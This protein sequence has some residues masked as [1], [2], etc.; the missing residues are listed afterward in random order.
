[1]STSGSQNNLQLWS[2]NN[3][4]FEDDD[5]QR[6]ESG[7]KRQALLRQSGSILGNTI[8]DHF[9]TNNPLYV[10]TEKAVSKPDENVKPV[11]G[12]IGTLER[13]ED[14]NKM[15]WETER[16]KQTT[17]QIVDEISDNDSL[18][19]F[20]T[21]FYS[22]CSD[23]EEAAPICFDLY[24]ADFNDQG[25]LVIT[26]KRVQYDES[27]QSN[28]P[29]CNGIDTCNDPQHLKSG[30][31]TPTHNRENTEDCQLYN[32]I[33]TLLCTTANNKHEFSCIKCAEATNK[34]FNE[35][36]RA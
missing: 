3:P 19:S 15:Q 36:T 9:S 27:H 5:R 6:Q 20:E 30:I 2:S 32:H 12:V 28:F 13:N 18:Q 23:D 11:S 7:S 14:K 17:G 24:D 22:D 31:L 21:I 35:I 8:V 10:S 25:S 4:G 34:P 1:M 33:L 26:K 16:V 29:I